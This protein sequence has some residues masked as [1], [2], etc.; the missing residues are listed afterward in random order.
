V[1]ADGF[2]QIGEIGPAVL[3][4]VF[5]EYELPWVEGLKLGAGVY[6]LLDESNDAFVQPY[7]GYHPPWPGRSRELLVRLGYE[8]RL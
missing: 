5:A 2:Q 6:D 4:H 8:A 3:L 7:N 1:D